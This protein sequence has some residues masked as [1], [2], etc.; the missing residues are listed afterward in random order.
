MWRARP[1][2]GGRV[3]L[4]HRHARLPHAAAPTLSARRVRTRAQSQNGHLTELP[5]HET[6]ALVRTRPGTPRPQ[7]QFE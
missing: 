7:R 4:R 1:L 5:L 2:R 6:T 3:P